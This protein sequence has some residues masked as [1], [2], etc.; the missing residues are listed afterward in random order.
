M[1]VSKIDN[2]YFVLRMRD[3]KG[4]ALRPY[5]AAISF[6]MEFKTKLKAESNCSFS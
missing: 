1:L 5:T 3:F 6:D 2:L 4:L